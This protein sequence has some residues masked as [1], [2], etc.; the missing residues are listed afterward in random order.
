MKKTVRIDGINYTTVDINDIKPLKG[1]ARGFY[2][3]IDSSH[4]SSIVSVYTLTTESLRDTTPC[5]LVDGWTMGELR[6]AIAFGREGA[7]GRFVGVKWIANNADKIFN[8]AY[9]V[10]KEELESYKSSE[11][12]GHALEN[13]L[14]AKKGYKH[15]TAKMDKSQK[16][17]VFCNGERWQCKCSIIP[18]ESSKRSYSKTNGSVFDNVVK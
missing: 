14:V 17:D 3:A 8:L 7:N 12:F 11:D 13:W 6:S 4:N 2:L 9:V 10:S 5:D 18:S 16:I 1:F 15:G